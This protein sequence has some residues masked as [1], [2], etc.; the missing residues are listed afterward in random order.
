MEFIIPKVIINNEFQDEKKKKDGSFIIALQKYRT[1]LISKVLNKF[2]IQTMPS[3]Y[4]FLDN[5]VRVPVLH[6]RSFSKC[7]P[8]LQRYTC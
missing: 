8:T 1:S 4:A 7:I 3:S 6:H 2:S 5:A